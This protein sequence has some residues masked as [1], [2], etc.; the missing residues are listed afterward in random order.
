[1]F[2]LSF[3]EDHCSSAKTIEV[4]SISLRNLYGHLIKIKAADV[5]QEGEIGHKRL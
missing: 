2:C 1:M 3:L 4:I 5:F